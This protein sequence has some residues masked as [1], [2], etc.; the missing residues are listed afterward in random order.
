MAFCF[1]WRKKRKS[2]VS[3]HI[4][5]KLASNISLSIHLVCV[6]F[7]NVLSLR[8]NRSNGK[9]RCESPFSCQAP[10]KVRDLQRE[11]DP[12]KKQKQHEMKFTLRFL[13]RFFSTWKCHTWVNTDGMLEEKKL[14]LME[15]LM[16]LWLK[17]RV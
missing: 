14:I 9:W 7:T 1:C 17:E 8:Q 12:F 15:F 6:F 13:C 4:E 3:C 5:P 16:R 2:L 11:Q 10:L